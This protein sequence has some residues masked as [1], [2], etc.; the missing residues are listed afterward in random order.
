MVMNST[1]FQFYALFLTLC[2]SCF[3]Q[4]TLPNTPAAQQFGAW[5]QAFNQDDRAVYESPTED[6]SLASGASG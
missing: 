4:T 1:E 2:L 6:V 3:A 5:L